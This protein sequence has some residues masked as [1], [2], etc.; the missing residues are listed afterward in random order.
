VQPLFIAIEFSFGNRVKGF[1]AEGTQ[2]VPA[3]EG[4]GPEQENSYD[5]A[6]RRGIPI[7]QQPGDSED[8][9]GGEKGESGQCTENGNEKKNGRFPDV[10]RRQPRFK[11]HQPRSGARIAGGGSDNLL[12]G[13][14][15]TIIDMTRSFVG[16]G[17]RISHGA[18]QC[19][20]Y[21]RP[22]TEGNSDC[23]AMCNEES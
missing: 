22:F 3:K 16:R 8:Q 17:G 9:P 13:C 15:D 10:L 14:T 7:Q 23:T 21:S 2:S 20:I 6:G 5:R 1:T 19:T 4:G 11:H 12:N 18:N